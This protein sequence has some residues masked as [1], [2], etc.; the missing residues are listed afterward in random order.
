MPEGANIG[1]DRRTYAAQIYSLLEAKVL[2]GEL[3]PGSRL[4]EESLAETFGVSRS[5]AREALADLERMGLAVRV[6]LRDRMVAVPTPELVSQKYDLWWVIDSGRTYLG[7]LKAG[8]ADYDELR[9]HVQGMEAG[10]VAQDSDAY[11][12]A[13]DAFHLKIRNSCD[14]VYVNQYSADC[15]IYMRWFETLYDREPEVSHRM[16]EEHY[17]ILAAFEEKNLAALYD[18]IRIHLN[19][20][21]ERILAHFAQAVVQTK[22][23]RGSLKNS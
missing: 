16:V 22:P 9:G 10:L 18:A 7:A 8:Q 20:Q 17:Q 2:S 23:M 21:R 13:C 12:A 19:H 15:D 4:S 5:P 14:N 3:Q 11:V 6:G 1:I